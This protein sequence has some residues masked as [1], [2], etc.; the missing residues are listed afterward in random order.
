[1]TLMRYPV[2]RINVTSGGLVSQECTFRRGSPRAS[3]VGGALGFS[4][5]SRSD[6]FGANVL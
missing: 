6:S 2:K 3:A 5:F 4:R 1:M